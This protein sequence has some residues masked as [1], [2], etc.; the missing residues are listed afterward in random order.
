V[1]EINAICQEL[2]QYSTEFFKDEIT[3]DELNIKLDLLIGRIERIEINYS[4]PLE[5]KNDRVLQ[6]FQQLLFK[7]KFKAIESISGLK[8]TSRKQSYTAKLNRILKNKLYFSSLQRTLQNTA[9][10]YVLKNQLQY[11]NP[12]LQVFK[13]GELK[14]E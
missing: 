9:K 1:N 11:W 2:I 3:K 12:N 10:A 5:I 7:S 4:Q 13:L 8:A 14:D 6:S